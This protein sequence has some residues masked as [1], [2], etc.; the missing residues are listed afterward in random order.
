MQ[1]KTLRCFAD[2]L[3]GDMAVFSHASIAEEGGDRRPSI[4]FLVLTV[5]PLP[6]DDTWLTLVP[7]WGAHPG[8][9]VSF[10]SRGTCP[11]GHAFVQ[12]FPGS[13]SV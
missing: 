7:M 1:R 3:P 13:E 8:T 5:M 9:R 12:F 6:D 4:G 11:I 2:L 10:A